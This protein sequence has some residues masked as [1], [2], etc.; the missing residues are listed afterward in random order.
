MSPNDES[1][2][3][4]IVAFPTLPGGQPTASEPNATTFN[5]DPTT[6]EDK[7]T[8]RAP[9]EP[10]VGMRAVVV[11]GTPVVLDG[12]LVDGVFPGQAITTK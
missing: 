4:G 9:L 6:I 1:T 10:S 3:G 2:V 11:M 7:A 12:K 5:F 8:Y